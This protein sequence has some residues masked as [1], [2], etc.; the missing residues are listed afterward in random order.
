MFNY[1]IP[2]NSLSGKIILV[3][4]AIQ[5]IGYTASIAYAKYGATVII[6]GNDLEKLEVLYDEIVHCGYPEPVIHHIDFLN[7]KQQDYQEVANSINTNFGVLNGL[8]LTNEYLAELRP[9]LQTPEQQWLSS[10]QLNV[11]SCFFMCKH[12]LAVMR[13]SNNASIILNSHDVSKGRA[14]W[15]AYSATKAAIE[16]LM[17]TLAD[18][19]DGISSV[20]VNCIN[21]GAVR[22][23]LRA[24]AYPLEDPLSLATAEDIMP[25]YMYL[26]G[27]DSID[28]SGKIINAQ[29]K[30]HGS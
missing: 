26:M 3:T 9:I 28:T 27:D 21:P 2:D 4:D 19:E 30:N 6:L 17:Y 14:Y 18:E 16:S 24:Q 22:T 1:S 20:R 25:T 29:H 5:E 10:F 8:L 12:L 15:G 23:K 7:C 13:K 11:H